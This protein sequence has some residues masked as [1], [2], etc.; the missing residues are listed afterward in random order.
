MSNFRP[1]YPSV[2]K[3]YNISN[4]YTKTPLYSFWKNNPL[5]SET[6]IDP[7]RSGY[8][9]YPVYK[10]VN[11]INQFIEDDGLVFQMPCSVILPCNKQY[12][13]NQQI[14]TQP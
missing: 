7:R 6:Y 5:S 2:D 13:A 4:H 14:V 11:K 9:P 10:S 12:T 1:W 3:P 8:N